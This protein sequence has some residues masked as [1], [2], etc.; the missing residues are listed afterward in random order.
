[1]SDWK[2]ADQHFYFLKMLGG[3][4]KL[5]VRET[6]KSSRV[7]ELGITVS[8]PDKASEVVDYINEN[9]EDAGLQKY[10]QVS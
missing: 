1:M 2:G 4:V 3:K 5:F 7:R 9:G 6:R 8:D 10:R